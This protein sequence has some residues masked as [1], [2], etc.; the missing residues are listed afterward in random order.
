[1]VFLYQETKLYVG[2]AKVHIP[3]EQDF[4]QGEQDRV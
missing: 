4:G 2:R 3:A 1:M